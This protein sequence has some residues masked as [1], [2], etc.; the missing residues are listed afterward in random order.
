M[1]LFTLL[2]S[3]FSNPPRGGV[4]GKGK[5]KGK[6]N[7]LSSYF[8]S[9]GENRKEVTP[10]RA[11]FFLLLFLSPC[12]FP[13]RGKGQGVFIFPVHPSGANPYGG[14]LLR[15]KELMKGKG[16]TLLGFFP[17]PFPSPRRGQKEGNRGQT[18]L[19][20]AGSSKPVISPR[21]RENTGISSGRGKSGPP[22]GDHYSGG[23]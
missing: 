5:G 21:R 19:I 22:K 7:T 15:G 18:E 10:L 9:F 13:L 20:P 16:L 17:I 14:Q 8:P 4:N 11:H 6:I 2:S 12:P 23:I 1:I 3:A